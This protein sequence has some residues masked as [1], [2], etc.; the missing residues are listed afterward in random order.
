M[1]PVPR[2]VINIH[3]DW[4]EDNSWKKSV[5]LSPNSVAWL[6]CIYTFLCFLADVLAQVVQEKATYAHE[7]V[8]FL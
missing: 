1:T 4:H 7:N 3:S 8:F 6:P 5:K 2:N